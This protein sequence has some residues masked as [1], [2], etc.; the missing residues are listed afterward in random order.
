VNATPKQR[1]RR[2]PAQGKGTRARKQ[3]KG[4][5]AIEVPH[6]PAP[7]RKNAEPRVEPEQG[8][9]VL[10]KLAGKT[11]VK[12][13]VGKV[14]HIDEHLELAVCFMKPLENHTFVWP[15]EQFMKSVDYSDVVEILT[16]P[17]KLKKKGCPLRFPF[18]FSR[19]ELA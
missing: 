12:Y 2:A 3:P 19:Y 15:Q 4:R 1:K 6:P 11:A 5:S 14:D 13:S 10:V 7:A 18:D 17:K 16:E 8:D 9:F